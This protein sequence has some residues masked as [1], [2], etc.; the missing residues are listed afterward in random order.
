MPVLCYFVIQHYDQSKYLGIH[1]LLR[2]ASP[3]SNT[4]TACRV[5]ALPSDH[6]GF[7]QYLN[8]TGENFS[9]GSKE[10]K[11]IRKRSSI[12][13]QYS[14]LQWLWPA[15]HVLFPDHFLWRSS[16]HSWTVGGFS[17][18]SSLD[19]DR[20]NFLKDLR[21]RRRKVSS[22]MYFHPLFLPL[23]NFLN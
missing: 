19:S 3:F 14:N 20:S 22:L 10:L 8:F 17:H 5:P 7:L 6:I 18:C 1:G 2:R 12:Q 16:S 21:V 4:K 11:L 23:L 13:L 9:D 15:G